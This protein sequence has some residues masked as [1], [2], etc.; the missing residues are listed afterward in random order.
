MYDAMQIAKY[1]I[2]YCAKKG[3][4]I[5]NLKL[6]KLLY[7][8]WIGYYNA[9]GTSLFRN[10]FYAWPLGPVVT[11]VYDNFCAYG[12]LKIRTFFESVSLL[13]RDEQILDS[14]LSILSSYTASQLVNLSHKRGKPW[15]KVYANGIGRG[16]CIPFEMIIEDECVG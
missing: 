11:D 13:E 7:F 1:T 8:L 15:Q 5:T 3:I 2:N 16:N 12:G 14:A 6:Q 4:S 9:T 10:R